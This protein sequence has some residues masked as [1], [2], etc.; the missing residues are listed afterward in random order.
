MKPPIIV[1]DTGALITLEK[2]GNGFTFIQK[3][4]S[5]VLITQAVY[6]EYQR[7]G[8]LEP[9][10]RS[11]LIVLRP[12]PDEIHFPHSALLDQGEKE[13]IALAP[14]AVGI[15]FEFIMAEHR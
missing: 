15:H 13:A 14:G 10:M 1:S 5:Q 4:F 6:D 9:H 7:R 2:L 12:S 11:G 3:L 8:N